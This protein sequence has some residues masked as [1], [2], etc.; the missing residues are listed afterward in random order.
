MP[1][2]DPPAPQAADR[3]VPSASLDTAMK[4]RSRSTNS[5]AATLLKEVGTGRRNGTSTGL[6]ALWTFLLAT[7]FSLLF[8]RSSQCPQQRPSLK[9]YSSSTKSHRSVLQLGHT[10]PCNRE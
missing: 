4:F 8:A 5:T 1:A 7:A 9:W 6:A 10:G 3:E 2:A